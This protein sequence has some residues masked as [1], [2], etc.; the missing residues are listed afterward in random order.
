MKIERPRERAFSFGGFQKG[1][2]QEK[3]EMA[4]PSGP[5]RRRRAGRAV[6]HVLAPNLRDRSHW[7]LARHRPST[8]CRLGQR[9]RR[10]PGDCQD[11]CMAASAR[12][13]RVLRIVVLPGTSR[14]GEEGGDCPARYLLVTNDA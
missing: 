11:F 14:R 2:G 1:C 12:D 9:Q 6:G 13:I 5:G 7:S 10:M 3:Q 4:L 8:P